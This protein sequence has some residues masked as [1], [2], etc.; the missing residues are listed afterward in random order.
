M[1]PSES[2]QSAYREHVSSVCTVVEEALQ[3]SAD[4]GHAFDGVVFHSGTAA[5]YHADDLGVPFRST[6]HFARL[7]PL[8]GPGHLVLC[9]P[10]RKPLIAWVNP[11]DHWEEG[12]EPLDGA[13]AESIDVREAPDPLAAGI[14]LGDLSRCAYVG[15][16]PDLAQR[17]GMP[18]AAVEPRVL[19]AVLD[20][21]RGFKTTWEI[22]CIRE[23]NRIAA[24]G[25]RA[26]RAGFERRLSERRIHADYLEAIGALDG[27]TPYPNIIAWDDRS[28]ILHYQ[29]K[30]TSRPDPGRSF[31]IDA[32][33]S[34]GGYASDVTRS[35][36]SPSAHPVFVEALD[37]ME[38]LQRD[39]AQSV[40]PGG[41]FV[42]LHARAVA[43]V[44]AI[45]CDLGVLRVG[46]SEALERKLALPFLPH[47]VG[48]HLGLQV[49]DVGGQQVDRAG[50]MRPP[51]DE[52]PYLRTTRD[53]AP[54][55]V[56]TVEPG[57]YFVPQLLAPHRSGPDRGCFEWSLV[58][59][60]LPCGGIRIEDDVRV[61]ESGSENLTRPVV[62]GHR[63]SLGGAAA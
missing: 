50:R 13:Y 55:Q 43:G 38:D 21:H 60:L 39:L 61:T 25:H 12:P 41:S 40:E 4:A 15:N 56:V 9:R 1:G 36:A 45:L 5:S 30:R 26:A 10:G 22:D 19:M 28:A 29:R 31:L 8:G 20:W 11:T 37:R 63:E 48:H 17:L 44:T 27:E 16:D 47:G 49:H 7:T 3:V 42:A 52:H 46:H 57:L 34:C 51:P 59:D 62:P 24:A 53:L 6:P 2:P 54:R 33:A 23:A 32:G 18:A 14:L 58:D 35:Y